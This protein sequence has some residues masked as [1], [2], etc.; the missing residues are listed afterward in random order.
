M[1]DGCRPHPVMAAGAR[2]IAIPSPPTAPILLPSRGARFG[3]ATICF[4]SRGP[5][6]CRRTGTTRPWPR[7]STR[8]GIR[9]R[10]QAYRLRRKADFAGR[11]QIGR[12]LRGDQL[13]LAGAAR[14]AFRGETHHP[15]LRGRAC[16]RRVFRSS[17]TS[18]TASP[19]GR[20]RRISPA[21]TTAGWPTL[22]RRCSC[23]L[24][25]GVRTRRRSSSASTMIST[26]TP[27]IPLP[28]TGFGESTRYSA[29]DAPASMATPTRAGGRSETG[30]SATRR[31]RGT[32]GHGRRRSW[33][34]GQREPM[35]VLYQ[36]IVNSPSNPGPLLGGINVDVDEV[37][38]ADYGQWDLNR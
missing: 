4:T 16:A 14:S 17:A 9:R 27:G 29:S 38:A 1:G 25:P 5:Q 36:A 18:S 26:S 24:R 8:R 34:H 15:R 35:A 13:R 11:D 21:D 3:C 31:V 23:T 10:H 12:V 33:S 7:L 20:L 19:V 30:S 22:R 6:I 2:L 28:S 32:A 37:L